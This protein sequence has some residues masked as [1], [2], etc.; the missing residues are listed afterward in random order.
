MVG[1]TLKDPP[2][3]AAVDSKAFIDTT[4]GFLRVS[5]EG[6]GGMIHAKDLAVA[7]TLRDLELPPE[8]DLAGRK[9]IGTLNN[10]IVDWNKQTGRDIADLND[11]LA[12]G[13]AFPAAHPVFYSF[14]NYFLLPVFGNAASYRIRPLGPEECL[15][16]IWSLTLF[17]EGEEPPPLPTP[18]VW[19]C[20]D[21]R[22]PPIPTQD[23]H[24]HAEAA[25]RAAHQ[26]L[27]RT[28]GCRR[29]PRE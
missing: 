9:L 22:I 7:E 19:E 15:F 3:V 17:P 1:T 4:I 26:G 2:A 27:R 20:D 28:C 13:L 11:L 8:P 21:S 29:R 18:E 6:M 24:E 12:K 25:A 23:F 14:P 5:G 16:E 10:A